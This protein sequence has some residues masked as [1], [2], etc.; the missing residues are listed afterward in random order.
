MPPPVNG[1]NSTPPSS[2]LPERI[3]RIIE[4][5]VSIITSILALRFTRRSRQIAKISKELAKKKRSAQGG[6]RKLP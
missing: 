6:D 2:P 5:I 1:L 3:L 4:T